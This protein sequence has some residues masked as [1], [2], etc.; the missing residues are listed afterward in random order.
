MA[1]LRRTFLALLA[2][3]VTSA[4]VPALAHE[5]HHHEPISKEKAAERAKLHIAKLVSQGDIDESWKT[6]ATLQ[7]AD[8]KPAGEAQHWVLVYANPES[9]KPGLLHLTMSETGKYLSG[10]IK[11]N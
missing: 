10:E 8:L 3:V 11:K 1:T 7:S 5:G 6:K 9:K 4:A 2:A